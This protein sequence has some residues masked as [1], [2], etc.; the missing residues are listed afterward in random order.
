MKAHDLSS[1]DY[2]L[3]LLDA[4][5]PG[6]KNDRE[7]WVTL[8]RWGVAWRVHYRRS[9]LLEVGWWGSLDHAQGAGSRRQCR[10]IGLAADWRRGAI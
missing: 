3:A 8:K 9:E 6:W 10:R 7:G 5:H 4:R 2:L 1:E